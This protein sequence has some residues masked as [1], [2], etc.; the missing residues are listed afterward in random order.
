M[1]RRH[2]RMGMTRI[3]RTL[4]TVLSLGLNLVIERLG[5]DPRWRCAVGALIIANEIRG[6]AVVYNVVGVVA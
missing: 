2:R 1:L 3:R 5:V 6:L 4:T